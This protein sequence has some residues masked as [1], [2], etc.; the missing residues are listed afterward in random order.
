MHADTT[1]RDTAM[2]ARPATGLSKI[3]AGLGSA[4]LFA[5]VL[6]MTAAPV[7]AADADSSAAAKP[8]DKEI[9]VTAQFR[10]QKLQDTPIAITAMNAASLEE[11]SVTNLSQ[12]TDV[13][14][15]VFLRAQSPAFGDSIAASIRGLGQGDFDPALEPGVGIYIDDV[16]FPRLTGANLELVD[17]DRVEVLRGPQGTLSGKNAEGGAIKYYSRLPDGTNAGSFSVGYGSRHHVT[18]NGTA[19]FTLADG[20]Y[21]R[22]SGAYNNQDGYVTSGVRTR[23]RASL[24]AW[25]A[26]IA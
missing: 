25:A 26:A 22:V 6:G 19:D 13:A 16:Y 20:L 5:L 24:R 14:P 4:S 23:V 11:R 10:S 8:D 21:G 12:A 18:V 17:V 2:T 3:M 7:R 15:S 9:I 1:A